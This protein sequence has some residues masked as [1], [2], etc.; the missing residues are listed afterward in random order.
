MG[1]YADVNGL[2]MYYE[3]HGP[4]DGIPLVLMHGALSATGSSFGAL[5]PGLAENRR[6][7]SVE[8]Q[9]H[10][11]TADI[12]RPLS[13]PQMAEDTAALLGRLGIERADFFGYSMGAGI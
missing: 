5:L 11:H 13:V 3:T 2:H 7:I 10:G 9:A 1:E 4:R 6:V 8:Q 12:D